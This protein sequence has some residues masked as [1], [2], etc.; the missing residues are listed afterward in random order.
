MWL[1]QLVSALALGLLG[2]SVFAEGLRVECP[3]V[4][5]VFECSSGQ[6]KVTLSVSSKVIA[7]TTIYV[8]NQQEFPADG[9][10]RKTETVINALSGA[11]VVARYSTWCEAD[12]SIHFLSQGLI[13]HPNRGEVRTLAESKWHSIDKSKL[14]VTSEMMVS[15]TGGEHQAVVEYLCEKRP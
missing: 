7:G 15:G 14:T 5:G 11:K 3:Q 6:D 2:S 1:G 13:S 12:Q 4:R 10:E 8:I 9:L